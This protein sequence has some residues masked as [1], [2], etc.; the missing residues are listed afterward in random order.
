MR[1]R[2]KIMETAVPARKLPSEAVA[3]RASRRQSK[4]MKRA[5][6]HAPIRICAISTIGSGRATRRDARRMQ[7]AGD[8]HRAEQHAAGYIEALQR[9]TG[10]TAEDEI[11]RDK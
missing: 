11:D 5:P 4:P 7:E 1:R 2:R 8:E 10:G 6:T 9:V 3:E